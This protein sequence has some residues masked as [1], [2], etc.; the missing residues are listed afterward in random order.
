MLQLLQL[1][2]LW[3]AVTGRVSVAHT[4]VQQ[5]EAQA[6]RGAR[7]KPTRGLFLMGLEARWVE[8]GEEKGGA[9]GVECSAGLRRGFQ[10]L[11]GWGI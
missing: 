5:G 9:A 6:E 4:L 2:H 3:R 10:W 11:L 8:R 7:V 1:L